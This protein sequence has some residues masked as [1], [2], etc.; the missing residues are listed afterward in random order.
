MGFFSRRR[1]FFWLRLKKRPW[2][3]CAPKD[4][5]LRSGSSAKTDCSCEGFKTHGSGWRVV[6]VHQFFW[7]QIRLFLVSLLR[8]TALVFLQKTLA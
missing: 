3:A 2:P 1:A 7:F 8:R 4:N 5:S 6:S